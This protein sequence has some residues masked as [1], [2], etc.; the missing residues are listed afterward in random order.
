MRLHL[1]S[2]FIVRDSPPLQ[3]VAGSTDPNDF[4]ESSQ[5]RARGVLPFYL[6][7][8]LAIFSDAALILITSLLTGIVYYLTVFNSV[9]PIETFLGVGVLGSVNFTA[10]LAARS[11]YKPH[12]LANFW[13]QAREAIAVWIFVCFV[14][15]AAA[16]SLKIS[17]EYSRGATLT[18]FIVGMAAIGLSRFVI[19]RFLVRALAVGAFAEQK[20][21]L[22]AEQGQAAASNTIAELN[23]CGYSLVRAFEFA[24]NSTP[25]EN[26][27]ALILK[28]VG[29]AV[30]I[31]RESK[32][33]CVFLLLPWENRR[34][35]D[36]LMTHLRVLS[37]PI[38][39]LPDRSVAHFLGKR[40]VNVGN[41][42][43]VELQRAPL[44]TAEQVCKRA[45]DLVCA[46]AALILLSPIMVLVA[47]WIKIETRDSALFIQRRSG[48]NG[49]TFKIYKFRT[50]SVTEDGSEVRQAKR[51]DPR[52]IRCGRLL[53][54]TNIDELPQLLNVIAGEM[55][56]VGPR[57][58]PLALNSEYENIVANY[59][60]R[61]HVKPG[62]TGWAQINGLRGETQTVDLM[63]RRVEL[64]L[65]YINNWS[66]W[67][68]FRILLGTLFLGLQA[69]AY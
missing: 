12:Y 21:I 44:T 56:L 47:A 22:F 66:L 39:L 43:T 24:S 18:F 35:I 49:R 13:M 51:N 54:R 61:H 58:H 33:E 40:N 42:S 17:V 6:V 41:S 59:A 65:W 37:I 30:E 2:G 63:A 7:E 28:A 14:L 50:M 69:T 53:R 27:A 52:I 67:L 25:F 10:I 34:L 38:Y 62:L 45:V 1:S 20:A 29:E 64:D 3:F 16:F 4:R 57:P 15:L 19:A 26:A 32:I 23:R 48:F 46:S 60:F 8:A 68:D 31:S 11:A 5:K 9:G 36:A 55:S